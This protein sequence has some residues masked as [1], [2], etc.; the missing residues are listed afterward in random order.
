MAPLIAGGGPAGSATAIRLAQ[1]GVHA[2]LIERSTAPQDSVCGAFL[3]WDALASIGALG[4][5]P[6]AL[7]AHRI[8]RVRIV[9]AGRSIETALPHAA[10]GLSR[11]RL[12]AALLA[13]AAAAGARIDRGVAI[14]AVEGTTLRLADEARLTGDALFL[15]TGKHDVRGAARPRAAAPSIGF[16]TALPASPALTAAL[17]GIIELHGFDGGYAGILLQEDGRAN[18]C[19]SARADRIGTGGIAALL[20]EIAQDA[21]L[22]ADRAAAATDWIAVAGVPYGWSTGITE[23]AMFR[24]GDQ[25]AVI[26]SLAGDGVAIALASGRSAADAYLRHGPGAAIA[27]QR[28]F[29]ARARRPLALASGIRHLAE[30]P[31]WHAPMAALIGIAPGSARI[32]ARVTRIGH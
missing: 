30:R 3:G 28:R 12:D 17:S 15:A 13:H 5:D 14:R 9:T 19:L 16:R 20:A 25:A 7:G 6:D 32:A 21:P 1:A 18:L 22:L 11:H 23:P 29:A 31:A 26:A 24:L 27:W 8:T 2:H 10:A 4:L